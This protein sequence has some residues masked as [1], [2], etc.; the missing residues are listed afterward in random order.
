MKNNFYLKDLN[1]DAKY[2]LAGFLISLAIGIAI[3]LFYVYLTTEM[4]PVGVNE[5]FRGSKIIDN[6]EIPNKFS[7]PLENMVL[8][9]HNHILSFSI[10]TLLIGVIFYFSSIIKNKFKTILIIEP[11]VSSI[12]MFTSL[13]LMKYLYSSFVYLMILSAICTYLC[14]YLMIIISIY[15]LLMSTD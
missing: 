7:K 9:T 2:F 3:G 1:K 5:Q 12:L 13:W 8:T 15:E 6:S 4:T 11:F 14:W 10:I